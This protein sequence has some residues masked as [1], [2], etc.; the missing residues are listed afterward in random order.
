M[1][2][3]MKPTAQT[4]R[5]PFL[6]AEP[7]IS[8]LLKKPDSG[9]MPAMATAPDEHRHVG[10]RDPFAQAAHPAHVLLVADGMDDGARS[11]NSRPLKKPMGHEVEDGGS[12]GPDPTRRTCSRAGLSVEYASTL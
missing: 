8:S 6:N 7:R 1:P 5:N 2:A 11:R 12:P 9:G 4:H 3:T 10:D